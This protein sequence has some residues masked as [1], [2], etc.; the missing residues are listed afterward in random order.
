LPP[1][2]DSGVAAGHRRAGGVTNRLTIAY[3]KAVS[4]EK[5]ELQPPP[6]LI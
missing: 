3:P 1:E 2:R 4:A 5:S 6:L